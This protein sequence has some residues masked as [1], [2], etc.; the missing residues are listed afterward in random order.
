MVTLLNKKNG[1][2]PPY[3]SPSTAE[4]QMSQSESDIS[5]EATQYDLHHKMRLQIMEE[6]SELNAVET[7]ALGLR[8]QFLEETVQILQ[9]TNPQ[10]FTEV[11][12]ANTNFN[13]KFEIEMQKN[14]TAI[15]LKD[16]KI[17]GL[18]HVVNNLE[19]SLRQL[20]QHCS[21]LS[22]VRSYKKLNK[23][24][25]A[26]RFYAKRLETAEAAVETLET[27]VTD[28]TNELWKKTIECDNMQKFIDRCKQE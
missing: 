25:G 24:L 2:T 10:K 6:T 16:A 20:N 1:S 21:E 15:A 18:E 19:L 28:L 27:K 13:K 23:E 4:Y 26:K 17:A 3:C 9:S 11:W 12:K 14:K 7:S 8:I 5:R 22:K